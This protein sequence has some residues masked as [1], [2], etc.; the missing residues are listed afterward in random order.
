VYGISFIVLACVAIILLKITDYMPADADD[1]VRRKGSFVSNIGI[2]LFI[3]ALVL[4]PISNPNTNDFK[5]FLKDQIHQNLANMNQFEKESAKTSLNYVLSQPIQHKD[6][7][8]AS[9]FVIIDPNHVEI[10][11]IGFLGYFIKWPF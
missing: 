6:Y 11:F 7:Y 9:E 3:L 10:K 5:E 4:L 2:I 8:F 1:D